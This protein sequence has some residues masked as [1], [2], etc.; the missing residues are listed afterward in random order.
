MND[1]I[2]L[3]RE[4]KKQRRLSIAACVISFLLVLIWYV[5]VTLVFIEYEEFGLLFISNEA[6][7]L[8]AFVLVFSAFAVFTSRL[9][10]R[11]EAI[12]RF[13]S[14]P[15]KYG[16]VFFAVFRSSKTAAVVWQ[17]NAAFL[18]GRFEDCFNYCKELKA[19]NKQKLVFEIAFNRS[20]AAAMVGDIEML[21]DEIDDMEWNLPFPKRK[22]ARFHAEKKLEQMKMLLA[23]LEDNTE[24]AVK[25][26]DSF[27]EM[28]AYPIDDALLSYYCGLVY[29]KAGQTVKAIHC[30]MT[31]SEKGGKTF[32]KAKSDEYLEELKLPAE[33]ASAGQSEE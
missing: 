14:D 33:P 8:F 6:L 12:L 17:A 18:S 10:A 16:Q 21:A 23:L 27:R 2:T 24:E 15:E 26:A 29:R 5:A 13:E 1:T 28:P 19:L 11:I 4:Y 22:K 7:F 3:I 20:R 32:V 31:A 25:K 9:H 30:F